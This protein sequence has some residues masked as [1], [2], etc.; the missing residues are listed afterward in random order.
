MQV[1]LNLSARTMKG[2]SVVGRECAYRIKQLFC[3]VTYK[4]RSLHGSE[5][6][7]MVD[8]EGHSPRFWDVLLELSLMFADHTRFAVEQQD[9]GAL[10]ALVDGADAILGH[11]CLAPSLYAGSLT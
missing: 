3:R 9:S 4:A 6:N 8:V 2:S 1:A 7:K 11:C 10:R 5:D